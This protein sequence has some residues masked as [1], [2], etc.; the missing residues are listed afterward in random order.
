[1][2]YINL[3]LSQLNNISIGA[4]IDGAGVGDFS[5]SSLSISS[6]GSRRTLVHHIRTG[7]YEI[8]D[9]YVY[10]NIVLLAGF[11]GKRHRRRG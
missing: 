2:H 10:T 5:G 6:D 11:S 7:T 4:D 3:Y 8:Q 1:V 9:M